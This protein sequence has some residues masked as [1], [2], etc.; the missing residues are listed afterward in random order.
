MEM[1]ANVL[2]TDRKD[3]TAIMVMRCMLLSYAEEK[4]FPL[5]EPCRNLPSRERIARCLTLMP[6]YGEKAQTICVGCTTRNLPGTDVSRTSDA[7]ARR[8]P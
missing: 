4:K 1:S 3:A 6:G 7:R 5:N 8:N 2:S